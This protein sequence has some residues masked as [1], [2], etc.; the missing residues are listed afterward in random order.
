MNLSNHRPIVLQIALILTASQSRAT[1]E[2]V[3]KHILWH[4][5]YNDQRILQ[6]YNQRLD[7]LLSSLDYNELYHCIITSCGNIQHYTM[8]DDLCDDIINCCLKA[9]D[10]LPRFKSKRKQIPGWN[11][12]KPF[13]DENIYWH[14][15]WVQM[16]R[17]QSGALFDNMRDARR[18]YKQAVKKVKHNETQLRYQRMA[19]A[20]SNHKSRDF[21]MNLRK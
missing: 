6:M 13:R 17:P 18:Q 9:G 20:T 14:G 16:G 10:V 15:L 8:I 1:C 3:S 4:K 12:I 5:V 19:E 21:L 11:E 7:Q 2:S